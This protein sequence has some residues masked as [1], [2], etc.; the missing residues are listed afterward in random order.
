MP[1]GVGG[2]S[3]SKGSPFTGKLDKKFS[4]LTKFNGTDKRAEIENPF[5]PSLTPEIES[6][7]R[8]YNQDSLWTRWRRGYE[9]YSLT[10]TYLGSGATGRNTRGDFR[11]YCAF[12]QFPGVFIPARMFTFPSTHSEIGEQMV[13][14]RDVNSFNFYNFGLPILAVRYMQTGKTG[15]YSQSGTALTVTIPDHGYAVG[16]SIYLNVTTGG[17]IDETLTVTSSTQNTFTCTATSAATTTG[18]VTAQ[19]VT[20]FTDPEWTEQRVTIRSIPTPVTFFAG[21]RLA[22]RVIERDPGLF[23]TYSRTGFTVTV[24]CSSAH[25]LSTGNEV[26]VAVTSGSVSS[27]LYVITVLNA[28]QFTIESLASGATAGTLIVNRRI[29]GFNYNDYVGYTVTG[30][31]LSTNEIKFQRQDSYGTRLFDPVTNLP[32][33]TGQG[34]PKTVVPAHRGFEVGKFLTTEVRYHCTCQD[35]LKRETFNFYKEAQRRRFPSTLPQSTKAGFRL[36]RDGNLIDT[37]DEVGVYSDFGYVVVN[38]FYQLPSYEDAADKS[39]P[40]LA[41][42]QLRWCK[43]IYAAMWSL[44]HDEGNDPLNLTG[45]YTQSGVNIIV[46]TDEPHGL[47]LNTRINIDFTSGDALDGEYIVSQ[48]IDANNFAIIYPF[49]QTTGGYC[50]VRN[51]RPHE[52]VDT[53]LLEPNDPP[54][55]K[56]AETFNKRLEKENASLKKASE[57]LTMMGY[58]MPWTGAK[59]ISGDR[60]QPDQVGNYDPNLVTLMVTDNIRRNADYDP[61]DPNSNRFSLTGTPLNVTTVML[62]VMQKLLNIDMSLIRSGKFGMLDQPLTDYNSD[63]RFGEIEC[64]TYLNGNPA[65]YNPATG[66]RTTDLLDCGTY[67]NGVPTT[68]PFTQIDCGIYLNT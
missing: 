3:R 43:H 2:F 13:G 58:G 63:F 11:M 59:S 18:N 61:N 20:V 6:E 16:D 23:S 17:G 65:D 51:L 32:S 33:A 10:Q 55:G 1:F 9:L 22:D 49:N 39:R 21:E 8:F 45:S 38:N 68:P 50:T 5:D 25:G 47:S 12:Q 36:D 30:V 37:R 67:V 46:K 57:R 31:D 48:V 35:Y 41:Y 29:R 56:M 24:T 19:R 34:I 62:T 27:G 66:A 14:I 7:I 28:T 44:A 52:Y 64:G 60:N 53:W 54:V 26:F 42:Y 15:T 40:L 4:S